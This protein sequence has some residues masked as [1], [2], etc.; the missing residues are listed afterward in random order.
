MNSHLFYQGMYYF[1]GA[2]QNI[3][4]FFQVFRYLFDLFLHVW[5]KFT[6][7]ICFL[8]GFYLIE[9][10]WV[11]I[12]CH[13]QPH[14]ITKQKCFAKFSRKLWP[15]RILADTYHCILDQTGQN[16]HDFSTLFSRWSTSG[17]LALAFSRNCFT[18]FKLIWQVFEKP[19][20][21]SKLRDLLR[22]HKVS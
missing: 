17:V 18:D 16:Y 20:I 9:K 6:C 2:L 3:S 10:T 7:F 5:W 13:C 8:L 14:P 19:A 22:D 15:L 12:H 21:V 4:A 11:T 1:V